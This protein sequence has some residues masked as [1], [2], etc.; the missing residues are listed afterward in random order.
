MRSDTRT[1]VAKVVMLIA[2][3]MHLIVNGS[4]R[5]ACW[6]KYVPKVAKRVSPINC[7]VRFGQS[8]IAV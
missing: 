2:D 1:T 6:K 8:E 4:D 5:S 3:V 7:C